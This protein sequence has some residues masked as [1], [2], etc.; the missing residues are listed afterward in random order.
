MAGA[1]LVVAIGAAAALPSGAQTI[2]ELADAQRLKQQSEIAKLRREAA[3]AEILLAAPSKQAEPVKLSEEE[4]KAIARK[5]AEASRP[6]IVLHSLY[7]RNGVWIAELAEGQ[8][9]AL[10]LVGMNLYGQRIVAIDQRG[11]HLSKACTAADVRE[12]ARC[13]NRTLNVGEAI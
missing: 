3:A 7:A 11:V 12:K 2:G 8:R 6:K 1:L 13:G 9:L 4:I 10:A 5:R